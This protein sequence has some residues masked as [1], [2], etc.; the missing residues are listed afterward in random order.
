MY[1]IMYVSCTYVCKYEC[2]YECMYVYIYIYIYVTNLFDY[3]LTQFELSLLNKGLEF[4]LTDKPHFFN[5]ALPLEKLAYKLKS[6]Q[7]DK[8]SIFRNFTD[9][10]RSGT[11]RL[12]KYNRHNI[13]SNLTPEELCALH[14]LRKNKNI[15]LRP[16][17][18]NGVVILN[19]VDYI[20]K[21]MNILSDTSKF[22]SIVIDKE[23]II[24]QNEGKLTNLLTY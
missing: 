13:H 4:A 24:R 9:N 11:F 19:K 3:K 23:K 8:S 20:S 18:G 5:L 14:T 15:I 6:L 12:L 21:I 22:Q 10:I 16:D 7:T 2:M 1:V 17:K